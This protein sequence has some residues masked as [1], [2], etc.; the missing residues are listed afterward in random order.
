VIR[1]DEAE[2]A[3]VLLLLDG[4][5]EPI[6]LHAEA[7][8][9][10]ARLGVTRLAVLQDG[11]TVGVLLEGWAFDATSTGRAIDAVDGLRNRIRVLLP[12]LDGSLSAPDEGSKAIRPQGGSR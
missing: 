3:I 4:V 8:R 6:K 5:D 7:G 12:V 11:G 10:L 1:D 9:A 2:M